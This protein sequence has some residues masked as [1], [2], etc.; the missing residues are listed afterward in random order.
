MTTIL[1]A[2]IHLDALFLQRD[3]AMQDAMA[4]FTRLPYFDGTRDVNSDIA[5]ISEEIVT[6]P[7]QIP[8]L[9]LGAGVHLHWALP[10]ALTHGTH[11]DGSTAF[12]LVPNRWLVSR[13]QNGAVT[14]WVV[15]SDYLAP[16]GEANAQ[17][18]VNVPTLNA[19]EGA[20]P[21]AIWGV[22]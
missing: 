18:R 14:Q 12:P 4:D 11:T 13:N 21:S 16:A 1:M 17:G 20:S 9:R 19:G 3:Q 5:Y 6:H 8:N 2:P 15:E 22:G 7:F 10:D